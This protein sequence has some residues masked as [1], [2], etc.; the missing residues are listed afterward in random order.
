M[1]GLVAQ[2]PVIQSIDE[3]KKLKPVGFIARCQ[4]GVIVGAMDY[5]R[6]E[7]A[8][9]SKL[10]GAWL[11]DGCTVSPKLVAPWSISVGVCKCD[12][13]EALADCAALK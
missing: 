3:M 11:A 5:E 7:R 10:L 2:P 9:A 1:L 12:D 13:S 8:E 6:T 4:C